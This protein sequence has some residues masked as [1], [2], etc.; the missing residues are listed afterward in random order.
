M[1]A[2]THYQ[3]Q[4]HARTD[5]FCASH[6]QLDGASRTNLL[7]TSMRV[8]AVVPEL[9]TMSLFHHDIEAHL[10]YVMSTAETLRDLLGGS[11][12]GGGRW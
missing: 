4:L 8:R 12:A 11:L 6:G 3:R 2:V 7:V 5:E 1:N 10:L 9:R